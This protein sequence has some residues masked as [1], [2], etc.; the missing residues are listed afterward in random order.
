MQM[1]LSAET[2]GLSTCPINWPDLE[3]AEKKI[4]RL[5]P[6]PSYQ[7]VIMLM[8]VGYA[9]PSGGIPYSQKKP[10]DELL[11]F[12]VRV[13]DAQ[14]YEFLAAPEGTGQFASEQ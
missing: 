4:A 11:N 5:L 8:A 14:P 13:A 6:L 3:A 1:M 2:L 12:V 9:D 7:R 10:P